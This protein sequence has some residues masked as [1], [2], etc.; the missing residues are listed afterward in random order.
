MAGL[1]RRILRFVQS[2]QG[3]EMI[4]RARAEAAKPENRRKLEQLR[5]RYTGRRR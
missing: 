5:R 4:R 1:G 2:P 3:Q